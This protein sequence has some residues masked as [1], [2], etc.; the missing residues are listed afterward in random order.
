MAWFVKIVIRAVP[1]LQR[2]PERSAIS[3]TWKSTLY[4][5]NDS[6]TSICVP[7]TN[8]CQIVWSTQESL[9]IKFLYWSLEAE[10]KP[11]PVTTMPLCTG[12][13]CFTKVGVEELECRDHNLWIPLGWLETHHLTF[14]KLGESLPRRMVAIITTK[15][16]TKSYGCD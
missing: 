13:I 8:C 10:H 16:G 9:C 7:S 11:V 12:K 14:Q 2:S 6:I 1:L 4:D 3:L 15:G 5:Q